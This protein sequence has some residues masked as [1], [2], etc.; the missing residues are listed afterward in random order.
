MPIGFSFSREES[1]A[2]SEPAL[3]QEKC[4]ADG[5]FLSG[6]GADRKKRDRAPR[7]ARQNDTVYPE[8]GVRI[9]VFGNNIDSMP[10]IGFRIMSLIFAIRDRFASPDSVLDKFGMEKGQ[11]VIDYGCGPGSYLGRARSLVGP[12]GMVYAVDIHELAVK[13]VTKRIEKQQ[14]HNVKAIGTDGK[15][16][17]LPDDTAD[18]IYALDMFHMVSD[19]AGFLSE[20]NRLCKR[21]G[22]LFI[23]NGHQTRAKAKSKI[24]AAGLWDM[25]DETERYMK[26]RPVRK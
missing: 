6:R 19:P 20:L 16:Y 11:T 1:A 25:A 7:R 18:V 4:H 17:S 12:E 8:E 10:N 5:T 15:R 26:L 23:D 14:W 22:C 3:P 24:M 13:A 21:T 2:A 9:G